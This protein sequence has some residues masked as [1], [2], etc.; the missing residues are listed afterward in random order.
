MSD[1][2]SRMIGA[3]V[4]S[5][6]VWGFRVR[7]VR[8]PRFFLAIVV[9]AGASVVIAST[10]ANAQFACVGTL[11]ASDVTCT[12]TGTTAVPFLQ[13]QLGTFNLTTTSSGA[14]NG[15]TTTVVDGSVTAT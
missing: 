7:T 4:V 5:L 10:D 9:V 12:N 6:R 11:G 2:R 15:I 3:G 14:S 8:A 13:D 1:Q